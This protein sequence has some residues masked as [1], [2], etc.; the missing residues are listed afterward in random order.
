[1]E[2]LRTQFVQASQK[3]LQNTEQS[4]YEHS[5]RYMQKY[6]S[7][8]HEL[9]LSLKQN[10]NSVEI[11]ERLLY[12]YY[13]RE[14]MRHFDARVAFALHDIKWGLGAA[15]EELE[16]LF[17]TI[18]NITDGTPT[19]IKLSDFTQECLAV[20]SEPNRSKYLKHEIPVTIYEDICKYT[21]ILVNQYTLDEIDI[22]VHQYTL[23]EINIFKLTENFIRDNEMVNDFISFKRKVE[24]LAKVADDL[25]NLMHDFLRILII[26]Q[27]P[28]MK[29]SKEF[30]SSLI[31]D[32]Q[33]STKMMV[34][35][36]ETNSTRPLEFLRIK[37][38]FET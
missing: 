13:I 17:S 24:H 16:N 29:E 38:S 3:W 4:S 6:Q 37:W 18:S 22:R 25:Y 1:M 19:N 28:Y 7:M 35:L 36:S 21:D 9:K 2:S 31:Y 27:K 26:L 12:A 15:L 8:I 30:I 34:D 23:D 33:W 14:W 10:P 32:L 5:R 11:R 20:D